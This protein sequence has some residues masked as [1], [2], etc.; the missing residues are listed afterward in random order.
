LIFENV[1]FFWNILHSSPVVFRSISKRFRKVLRVTSKTFNTGRKFYRFCKENNKKYD[2]KEWETYS[3]P[4]KHDFPNSFL[5]T[6]VSK[7]FTA[8]Y[9]WNE[10]CDAPEYCPKNKEKEEGKIHKDCGSGYFVII[11]LKLGWVIPRVFKLNWL[12]ILD[13][14]EP[15]FYSCNHVNVVQES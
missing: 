11:G 2:E 9:L 6:K 4:S 13:L 3:E 10:E 5:W 7:S 14:Q 12:M 1:D 15:L 8:N